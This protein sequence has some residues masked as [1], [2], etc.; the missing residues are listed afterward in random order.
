MSSPAPPNQDT[1][2]PDNE[3]VMYVLLNQDL[4]M[5]KGK[6]CSQTAHSVT[7]VIQTIERTVCKGVVDQSYMSWINNGEPTIVLKA[8]EKQMNAAIKEYGYNK[9]RVYLKPWCI[10]M[11][12][13]GRT[14]IASN[15]LTT[16]AFRP[17]MRRAVPTFIKALK[18]L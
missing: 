5:G 15:S 12:D 2:D 1:Y 11:R 17:M 3:Q 7:S 6:M 16:L 13:A 4:K 18:L 10:P 9:N 14:Q 8:T